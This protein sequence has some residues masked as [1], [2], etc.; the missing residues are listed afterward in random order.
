MELVLPEPIV[1]I[2]AA[3]DTDTI[4]LRSGSG[5]LWIAGVGPESAYQSSPAVG[6]FKK[7]EAGSSTIKLR[8]FQ[9]PN[10]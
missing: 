3:V 7:Q 4:V 6:R 8:K 2:Y 9:L 1:S 10:R 5:N